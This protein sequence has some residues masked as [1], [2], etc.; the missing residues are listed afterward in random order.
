VEWPDD[1]RP[2]FAHPVN[3]YPHNARL[4]ID[5]HNRAVRVVKEAVLRVVNGNHKSDIH[6]NATRPPEGLAQGLKALRLD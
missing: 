5:R 6:E 2:P 4:V 3:E 1:R